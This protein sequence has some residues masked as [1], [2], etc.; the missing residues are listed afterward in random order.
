[1]PG[2]PTNEDVARLEEAVNR[3]QQVVQAAKALGSPR[4]TS[5]ELTEDLSQEGQAPVAE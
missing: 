4:Q 3:M 2:A 5:A 1:M